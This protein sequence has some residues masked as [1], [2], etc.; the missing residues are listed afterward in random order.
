MRRPGL[1]RQQR[2]LRAAILLIGGFTLVCFLLADPVLRGM[3]KRDQIGAA[4]QQGTAV[5]VT[6]VPPRPQADGTAE[7]ALAGV[8]FRGHLYTADHVMD[9]EEVKL[10][11]TVQIT[12][13]VGKSGHIYLDSIAP[14]PSPRTQPS[15]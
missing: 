4:P 15:P 10:G 3:R 12:Y 14:L 8:R 13:R 1:T 6:L 7:P 5:V 11:D 9:V 2:L